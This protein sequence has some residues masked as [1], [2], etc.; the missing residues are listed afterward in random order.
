[1]F[2]KQAAG[3]LTGDDLVELNS[4]TGPNDQVIRLIT[5]QNSQGN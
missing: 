3:T 2:L 4:Y 1:M 5:L